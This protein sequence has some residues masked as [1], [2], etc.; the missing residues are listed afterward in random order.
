MDKPLT[1]IWNGIEVEVYEGPSDL[2]TWEFNDPFPWLYAT[3]KGLD[4]VVPDW[5]IVEDEWEMVQVGINLD[6]LIERFLELEEGND[7]EN[8]V[9]A[10]RLRAIAALE[11]ALATLRGEPLR[12]MKPN[13]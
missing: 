4:F 10:N 11:R 3:E 1:N 7:D 9:K 2:S 8:E 13:A 5:D 6:D 12:I